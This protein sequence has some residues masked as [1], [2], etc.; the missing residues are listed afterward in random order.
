MKRDIVR[1]VL[2]F[3]CSPYIPWHFTF[4]QEAIEK[5]VG[6]FGTK[7]KV[8]AFI[9]DHVIELGA[10]AG[11]FTD[12]GRDRFCDVFGITWDR[13]VDKG[14]GTVKGCLIPEPTLKGYRLPDPLDHRFFQD[15]AEKL[16]RYPDRFR[17]SCIG[18][19]LFERA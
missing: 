17:V 5:L 13:S 15:I 11:F 7:K 19:S 16:E 9:D 14:I 1:M 12:I 2:E 8:N 6:P 18:F 10:T 3:K 4:A